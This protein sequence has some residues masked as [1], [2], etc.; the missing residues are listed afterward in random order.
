MQTRLF[1]SAVLLAFSL[2]ATAAPLSR[3]MPAGAMVYGEMT[4]LG[5][6]FVQLRDSKT[7]KALLASPQYKSFTKSPNFVKAM[8]S[9]GSP[10]PAMARHGLP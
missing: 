1:F 10:S 4:G 5:D 8:A 9:K 7:L 2:G 6:K 3:S